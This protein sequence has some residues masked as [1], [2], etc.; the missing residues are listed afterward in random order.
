MRLDLAADTVLDIYTEESKLLS[1]WQI[2][3][4][5]VLEFYLEDEAEDRGL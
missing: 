4:E 3:E 2:F 1:N 5:V